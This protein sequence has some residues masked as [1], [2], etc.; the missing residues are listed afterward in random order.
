[1]SNS[2]ETLTIYDFRQVHLESVENIMLSQIKTF[3]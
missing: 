2:N 3:D 1:M